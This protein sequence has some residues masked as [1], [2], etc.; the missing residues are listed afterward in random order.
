MSHFVQVLVFGIQV[1]S[2][3]ALIALGYTMVY[4]VLKLINFAHG[5]V[6]MLGWY[7][8]L[9]AIGLAAKHGLGQPSWGL[10]AVVMLSATVGSGVVGLVIERFAYRPL[11]KAPR[12]ASLIT[13]IGVSLF[14]E[15]VVALPKIEGASP[16]AC[17]DIV[18]GGH[19]NYH[20]LGV[21][22]PR[23]YL[24]LFIATLIILGVLWY[25][26]SKTRLGRAMRAVSF[27]RDAASLMGVNSNQIISFT[28][29][30]GSALAGAAAC[31]SA[32]LIQNPVTPTAGIMPGL[33]AFVA[34][35]IGGIGNIPGAAVGGF[36]MGLAEQ[37]VISYGPVLHIS[38]NYSDAAAFAILI[39]VLIVRPTGIF[40]KG[41]VEKV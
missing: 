23:S 30:L 8:S 32:V 17:P 14:L 29:F 2:I 27:D 37:L 31:L 3:Y 15:N 20:W 10:C 18:P 19:P 21:V 1:G 34:A 5:D 38:S 41:L 35:V 39:L 13:A 16:Q 40:G 7:F 6:Y 33:K 24:I 12:L 9:S 22:V 25:I 4:G 26:V 36:I 11:R 28:F